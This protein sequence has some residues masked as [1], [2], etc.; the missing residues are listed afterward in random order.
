M[1]RRRPGVAADVDSA[2]LVEAAPDLMPRM[3]RTAAAMGAGTLVV[4]LFAAVRTKIV[5]VGLGPQGIGV[6]SLITSFLTVV[7][8]AFELGIGASAVREIAAAGDA[9][10]V[11][12]IRRALYVALVASAGV[13]AFAVLLTAEPVASLIL[14]DEGEAATVRWGALGVLALLLAVAPSADMV[15]AGHIARLARAQV[16]AATL[17][18][19]ATAAAYMTDVA[20]LPVALIA[21]PAAA[22]GANLLTARTLPA[23]PAGIGL[24]E[25]APDLRRLLRLG[26]ALVANAGIAAGGSSRSSA[27]SSSAAWVSRTQDSFKRRSRSRP[28]T[29][30]FC[31]RAWGRISPSAL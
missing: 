23:L 15:A 8:L 21:P 25:V 4:I 1:K 29:S 13:A 27:S 19:A 26:L 31:S 20:L 10:S 12:R 28:T 18:T 14:G 9:A 5:A 3:V 6:L 11:G 30:A 22:A 16:V 2:R 24:H 17:A 7:S